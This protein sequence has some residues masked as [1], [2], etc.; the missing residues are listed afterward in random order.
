[1]CVHKNSIFT[2]FKS[3]KDPY[4]STQIISN[5]STKCKKTPEKK[6]VRELQ[7][8]V[9]ESSMTYCYNVI[10]TNFHEF[11]REFF[12]PED[13]HVKHRVDSLESCGGFAKGVHKMEMV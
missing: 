4:S 10:L 7:K 2:C 12:L 5:I 9:L 11:S 6:I 3:N 13:K 8:F 1:M